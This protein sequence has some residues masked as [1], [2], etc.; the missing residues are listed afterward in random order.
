MMVRT[1]TA[2]W[3]VMYGSNSAD[4]RLR[5]TLLEVGRVGVWALIVLA[6]LVFPAVTTLLALPIATEAAPVWLT[7]GEHLELALGL[8]LP[9]YVGLASGPGYAYY[10][11]RDVME[12]LD[13]R[14]APPSV[15]AWV[16]LS[17]LGLAFAS[18]VGT[19]WIGAFFGPFIIC[20]LGT[21]FLSI[22][23]LKRRLPKP[24]PETNSA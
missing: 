8:G 15:R 16:K 4:R 11:V 9:V 6:H 3:A 20:P 10:V 2:G 23:G 22:R 7:S 17:L 1:L 24:S 19:L 5:S 21:A 12:G 14:Q 18:G 13:W